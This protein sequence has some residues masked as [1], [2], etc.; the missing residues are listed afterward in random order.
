MSEVMKPCP[1]CGGEAEWRWHAG[2]ALWIE[3]S[4]CGAV[5]PQDE[6]SS[7]ANSAAT[8]A[9][10]NTRHTIETQAAE[11]EELRAQLKTVLDREAETH[12]RHDAKVEAQ[13][14]E[15]AEYRRQHCSAV[16]IARPLLD[17][18]EAQAAENERLK[19]I[20]RDC[21]PESMSWLDARDAA[22]GE[23]E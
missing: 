9:A 22:L 7:D 21:D 14:A 12:R 5:G 17:A 3:C 10:W 13:A 1:F 6:E 8:I 11:I 18:L 19:N 2:D 20:L 23:T 16:E 15:I 4:K